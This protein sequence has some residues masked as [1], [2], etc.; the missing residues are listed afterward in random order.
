MDC[1]TGDYIAFF[2]CATPKNIGIHDLLKFPLAN[3]GCFFTTKATLPLRRKR[4]YVMNLRFTICFSG[5]ASIVAVL[6]ASFF[7]KKLNILMESRGR[8]L[9]PLSILELNV[10]ARG[11]DDRGRGERFPEV[12][13]NVLE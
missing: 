7:N 3:G 10:F 4:I 9:L 2:C 11:R 6:Q 1:A 5:V 8:L 13:E 12:G